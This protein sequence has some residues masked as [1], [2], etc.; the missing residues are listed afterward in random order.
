MKNKQFAIVA[1][2]TKNSRALGFKNDLPW[3]RIIEDMKRF[4][5]ITTQ[6]VDPTK[7]NSVIM[8]R[9]SWD[10]LPSKY[11]PL[12]DR[13]NVILSRNQNI[14]G[15]NYTTCRNLDEALSMLENRVDIENNFVIG[16]QQIY[17]E[18]ILRPECQKLHLT[19]ISQEF[20]ADTYF[21]KIP[22]WY[23][24]ESCQI[25]RS[26]K[27]NADLFFI[28]YE[29]MMD[30]SSDEG[31]YLN[32]LKRI[33]NEGEIKEDRTGVGVQSVFDANLR[34]R[35]ETV[36]PDEPD[37]TK[38]Q[39]RVPMLTTKQ[40]FLRGVITEL[41]WFLRG[42]TDANWLTSRGVH[43]WDGNTTREFLDSRG[44]DY[45]AGQIGP[46]YGHQWVNWGGDWKTK[47][48]GI[49]QIQNIID[50]LRKDPSSRRAILSAWN[51]SDLNKMALPPCHMMYIFNVSGIN[52]GQKPRLNCKMIIRSNDMF[53]G[54]PFN[55]LSTSVLTIL[56]SRALNML[57]GDIAISIADA[58]IYL[59]H[60]DQVHTQ[61]SRK[62]Y[63]FP[64]L[65]LNK[66]IEDWNQMKDLEFKD[67]TL[68]EYN[69][70]PS[71]SAQ[72]AV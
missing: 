13:F 41:I 37:Q 45:E 30:F 29:N 1:A 56:I 46:G 68:S 67:F 6:T 58:H 66:S 49:N 11:K 35:M 50:T 10:A 27:I 5:T 61:L 70:W 16:G 22:E 38:L 63:K 2:F 33:L 43:I 9:N 7:K 19:E 71:I 60:M 69:C 57:P 59:N 31:Q 62:P 48:G 39:Y 3:P 15:P 72:M 54:S 17:N 8:G 44:L 28:D 12:P 23:R 21:P 20:E 65:S 24:A 4:T 40:L 25:I 42:E 34:F 55:I 26:N 32:L 64:L 53:L 52:S 47:E 18:A 51:V 14:E 36:N